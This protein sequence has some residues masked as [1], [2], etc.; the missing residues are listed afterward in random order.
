MPT[1]V[2]V[3]IG[4]DVCT[5]DILSSAAY[6]LI[7]VAT[8]QIDRIGGAFHCRLLLKETADMDSESLRRRFLDY[9]IDERLRAQLAIKTEP[10]RNLIL[11]L[12]FGALAAE[13][14]STPK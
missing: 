3:E 2:L 12:A 7:D 5:L 14:E 11:S 1:E 6:R 13:P 9:L 4:E 8:C 10:I